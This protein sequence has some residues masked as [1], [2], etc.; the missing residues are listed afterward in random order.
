MA[1]TETRETGVHTVTVT[2][3]GKQYSRQTEPRQLLV[4]FI[5]E[6]LG[7]TGDSRGL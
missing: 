6:Q 2:V 1:Q 3:N 5:R 4:Y 7:L